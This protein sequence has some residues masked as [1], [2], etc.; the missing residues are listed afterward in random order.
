MEKTLKQTLQEAINFYLKRADRMC[1]KFKEKRKDDS[2]GWEE[3]MNDIIDQSNELS[4]NL[5]KIDG[6]KEAL[7]FIE[8]YLG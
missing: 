6:I 4:Y 8:E 1:G 7:G 3:K 5:G 2:R